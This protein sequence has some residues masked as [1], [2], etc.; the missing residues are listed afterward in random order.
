LE[1]LR[2]S[3]PGIV[4]DNDTDVFNEHRAPRTVWRSPGDSLDSW[5]YHNFYGW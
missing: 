4:I 3:N 2:R 5:V 1:A